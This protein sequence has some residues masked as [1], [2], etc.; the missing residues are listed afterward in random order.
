MPLACSING[1]AASFY[2]L[3]VAPHSLS[4]IRSGCSGDCREGVGG[5]VRYDPI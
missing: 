1:L 4:E 3:P 5:A 2:E